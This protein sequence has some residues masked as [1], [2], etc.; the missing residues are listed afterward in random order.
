MTCTLRRWDWAV[1]M[2][3]GDGL[4][5]YLRRLREGRDITQD[6]L[7]DAM[8]FSRRAL[9][10]WEL[11]ETRSIKEKQLIRAMKYL[12]AS[13]EDIDYLIDSDAT[14]EEGIE[15]AEALLLTSESGQLPKLVVEEPDSVVAAI[16]DLRARIDHLERSVGVSASTAPSGAK[17]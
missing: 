17:R 6:V 15:R 4:R 3:S 16:R 10:D 7:A 11:G 13:I 14:T 8:G 9:I 1:R 2:A 12:G 5:A